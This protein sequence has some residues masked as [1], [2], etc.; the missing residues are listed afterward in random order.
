MNP[1]LPIPRD[2]LQQALRSDL[3]FVALATIVLAVGLAALMLWR[4]RSRDPLLLWLG[5]G[6]HPGCSCGRGVKRWSN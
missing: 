3:P 1:G 6:I 2:V 4:L 5:P